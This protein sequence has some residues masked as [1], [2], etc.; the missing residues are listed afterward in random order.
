M[1]LNI[2]QHTGQHH[3][4]KNINKAKVEKPCPRNSVLLPWLMIGLQTDNAT[5]VLVVKCLQ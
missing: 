4:T 5:C 2:V 1:L 3:I